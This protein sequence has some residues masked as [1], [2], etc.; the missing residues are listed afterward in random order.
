M[1]KLQ[2]FKVISFTF[3]ILFCQKSF[4]NPINEFISSYQT[5]NIDLDES[6]S[7]TLDLSF[8]G[9][10]EGN[11]TMNNSSQT[12][13]FNGGA[14]NGS[15]NGAGKVVIADGVLLIENG[16][17]TNKVVLNGDIGSL[18]PI[19]SLIIN[20]AQT[21]DLTINNNIIN[22][23][24]ALKL[25]NDSLGANLL[26]GSGTIFA[27]I[28]G[29]EDG[30][31][32]I[33]FMADNDLGA[34]VGTP[35]KSL[36][37]VKIA[38]N[39]VLTTNSKNIDATKIIIGN[40]AVLSYGNGDIFGS[41]EGESAGVGSF[42]FNNSKFSATDFSI[43]QNNSPIANITVLDGVTIK[44]GKSIF[45][46]NINLALGA[47]LDISANLIINGGVITGEINGINSGDG[48]VQF[49]DGIVSQYQSIG[50]IKK[51]AQA[52]VLNETTLNINNNTALNADV[53]T[54]GEGGANLGLFAP[55]LN[56]SDGSIGADSNSEIKLNTNAIFNYNGGII[57]GV[58][59]GTSYNKGT[60]NINSD[61]T[62]NLEIGK[63][64]D[65]ANLNITSGK[66]LNINADIS[67]NN[68]FVAGNFNLGNLP[69]TIN[70]NL[71]TSGGGTINLG[72][73]QHN[74]NGNF[75]VLNGDYLKINALNS[76]NIG[77]LSVYGVAV[78]MGGANLEL[79]FDP[80]LGYVSDGLQVAII[81]GGDGSNI[82]VISN[83]NISIN[84]SGSNQSGLITFATTKS[85]NNLFLNVRR[86]G[87]ESFSKNKYVANVFDSID[88]IGSAATG[89]LRNLQKIM[90]SPQIINSTREAVLKSIIPQNTQDL[91]N[92]AIR[93]ANASIEVVSS[94]L[95]NAL[96]QPKNQKIVNYRNQE[97]AK[98]FVS[99]FSKN[100]KNDIQNLNLVNFGNLNNQIFDDQAFWVRGFNSNAN[101]DNVGY[102][103]GYK[104]SNSGLIVGA[105]QEIIKDLRLGISSSFFVANI[106]SNSTNKK[107]TSINSYQFGIYG[108]YNFAP[109]FVSANLAVALNKYKSVREIPE[110]NLGTK[111]TY[112]GQT[113]VAKFE[114]G[115]NK[116][117]D[118]G[119]I[120]IPKISLTMTKNQIATYS[121]SGAGTLDLQVSNASNNFLEA[122]LGSDFGY[123]NLTIYSTKVKPKIK[124]SYGYDLLA[125]KQSSKNNFVGQGNYFIITNSNTNK[126]SLKYGF[127]LDLYKKDNVL[128]AVD[129]EVE[130]KS[131][132]KSNSA[133][134]YMRYNF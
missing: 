26:V 93:S 121:E 2:L 65:L 10:L 64:Y 50:S 24:S 46:T 29:S 8:G 19:T 95:Q 127:G 107:T 130:Q 116:F 13:T 68:I 30:V 48:I 82:N 1:L 103:D 106:N 74:I 124:L 108:G 25:G 49:S 126:T 88:Q 123:N 128:F 125:G 9:V 134:L 27:S 59:R 115:M 73:T 109:Y 11:V 62:S 90:D 117:L 43:G 80:N 118:C 18:S 104:Y 77:S 91:N 21:L 4:A 41:V 47:K 132:Y 38:D 23:S 83:D 66:T 119:L 70:G 34:N 97:L 5:R 61:Y 28:Q 55:T 113:Y 20:D 15:I 105:D 72:T 14:I 57:N 76:S 39:K 53:V 58:V 131:S 3:L 22:A 81:S 85:G 37:L 33:E 96:F 122:R 133:S 32:V 7:S 71:A 84:G 79:T 94:R 51:I 120:I 60:F 67:A 99:L 31:G 110:M 78:V 40:N 92:G 52:L 111:A 44:I 36:A 75:S 63:R 129:Y 89:Q 17:E 102:V 114:G 101:Q 87:V 42:V 16:V 56:Q 86:R 45:A 35:T 98:S 54:I 12:T 69:K 100:N 112:G 6:A